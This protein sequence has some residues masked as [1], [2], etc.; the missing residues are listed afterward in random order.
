LVD[1]VVVAIDAPMR[2]SSQTE[3]WVQRP[4]VGK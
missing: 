4:A 1:E 3:C 2:T